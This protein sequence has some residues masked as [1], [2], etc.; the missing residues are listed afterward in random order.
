MV[1]TGTWLA[2]VRSKKYLLP[3]KHNLNNNNNNNNNVNVENDSDSTGSVGDNDQLPED[4]CAKAPKLEKSLVL[5]ALTGEKSSH[6]ACKITATPNKTR[7]KTSLLIPS[8]IEI[9]KYGYKT[10]TKKPFELPE[11]LV[12]SPTRFTPT[13]ELDAWFLDDEDHFPLSGTHS[14]LTRISC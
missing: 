4:C 6:K 8:K 5:S 1:H 11:N 12:V 13:P 9:S 2:A 7:P 10:P 14:K 3:T